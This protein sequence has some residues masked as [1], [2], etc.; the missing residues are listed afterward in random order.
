MANHRNAEAPTFA[1]KLLRQSDRLW[2]PLTVSVWSVLAVLIVAG[3][4][5]GEFWARE[6]GYQANEVI[7]TVIRTLTA[8]GTLASAVYLRG[9]RQQLSRTESGLNT[10]AKNV[11]PDA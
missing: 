8:L 7:D 6:H 9:Q 3:T 2:T 1:V 5:V 4:V 11:S 10:L